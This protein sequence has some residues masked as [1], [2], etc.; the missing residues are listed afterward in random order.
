MRTRQRPERDL[1]LALAGA[2]AYF[3]AREQ[4]QRSRE[5]DLRGQ[6]VFI[7]GGSRG[8]GMLI[9]R[10]FAKLGCKIAIC[11]RDVEELSRAREYLDAY[12]TDIMPIPCDVSDREQVRQVVDQVTHHYGQIDILVN[13]AGVIQVGPM[14]D[15]KLENYEEA[16]NV[17]YWGIV[18]PTLAVL[19][20]MRRRKSGRIVNITSVGGKVSVPHL[21]PYSSAKFA[22]V[23]F[24]EGLHAEL[25]AEG[26]TVTTICPGVLRDGA[27]LNSYFAGRAKS[28]YTWFSLA[29][30]L[31]IMSLDSDEAARQIV[32]AC[33]RGESER[34]L[35]MPAKVLSFL[36]GVFPQLTMQS[37]A[38]VNRYF[39]PKPNASGH[40]KETRRGME[41]QEEMQQTPLTPITTLGL[42]A[43]ERNNEIPGP[44]ETLED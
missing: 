37:L 12:A 36:H 38:L 20:Q 44:T 16:M 21:L 39:L 34:L 33:R 27:Q 13:N 11:A 24:S 42:Q 22:A 4:V 32:Q 3:L 15:M 10:E 25:A 28:E 7:T 23:G 31:P 30:S 6:V 43:A 1:L 2:G 9:A 18:Y 14:H 5:A 35:G 40:P 26:I 8:L 29:A 41:I 17:M 19:P